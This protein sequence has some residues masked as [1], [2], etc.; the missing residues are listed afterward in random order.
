LGHAS[1]GAILGPIPQGT[2]GQTPSR[3]RI[4][5]QSVG[6]FG[7]AFPDPCSGVG[8]GA[9]LAE[10]DADVVLFV[11]VGM[12]WTEVDTFIGAIVSYFK[13]SVARTVIH[14]AVGIVRGVPI[15]A[16][17]ETHVRG[18]VGIGPSSAP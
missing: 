12:T 2:F 6:A 7:R 18:V 3:K 1:V 11:E 16:G 17:G 9:S 14:A 8:E 15:V 4:A 5:I 13:G 10:I